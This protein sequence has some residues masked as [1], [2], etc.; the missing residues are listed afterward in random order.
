[1]T[2]LV[3][4]VVV[5]VVKEINQRYKAKLP[6]P[7]PIE[8][9]VVSDHLQVSFHNLFALCFFFLINYLFQLE[10]NYFTILWWFLQYIHMNQPRVYM[11]PPSRT[12]LPPPSGLSQ[13]TGFE[14]PVSCIELGLVIYFTYGNIHVPMLF[15]Q[16]IPPSPSAL[17]FYVENP[18]SL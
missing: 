3:I 17:C 6:V 8:L 16:I 18:P 12:P 2:S 1:M 10:A 9:I 7:I 15:S 13:Y 4:L 11:C 5:F 14:C